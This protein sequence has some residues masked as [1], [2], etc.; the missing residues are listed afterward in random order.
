MRA[1]SLCLIIRARRMLCAASA[2]V[3]A[4]FARGGRLEVPSN[5]IEVIL[6]QGKHGRITAAY[7]G[8]PARR[9]AIDHSKRNT[10]AR[11]HRHTRHFIARTPLA[12]AVALAFTQ[13]QAQQTTHRSRRSSRRSSSPPRPPSASVSGWGD[14]PLSLTPIQASVFGAEQ[15][16]DRGVQR[17]SDLTGFD[18]AISD[19]YNTGATGT[20]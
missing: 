6:A 4:A 15:T 20:I 10:M 7:C 19:A 12:L 8:E 2:R 1:P 5:L 11:L 3:L 18:A 9:P 14:M 13:A 16:R 17:L